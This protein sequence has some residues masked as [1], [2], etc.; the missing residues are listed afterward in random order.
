[1]L[2]PISEMSTDEK[3]ALLDM[4]QTRMIN[5]I[6]PKFYIQEHIPYESIFKEAATT[7]Y[8]A[9]RIS[10]VPLW[11]FCCHRLK[12]AWRGLRGINCL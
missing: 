10:R 1:M 12:M 3:K 6:F 4:I 8:A 9:L 7:G 2:K 11:K 5:K